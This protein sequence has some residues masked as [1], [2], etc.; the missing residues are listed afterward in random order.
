[1]ILLSRHSSHSGPPSRAAPSLTPTSPLTSALPTALW[2]AGTHSRRLGSQDAD[3]D[4]KSWGS[5]RLLGIN[6]CERKRRGSP[7]GQKERSAEVKASPGRVMEPMLPLRVVLSRPKWSAFLS[8][9]GQSGGPGKGVTAGRQ[10]SA[11]EATREAAD[12]RQLS[13]PGQQAIPWGL[14]RPAVPLAATPNRQ[15]VGEMWTSCLRGEPRVVAADSQTRPQHSLQLYRGACTREGTDSAASLNCIWPR[16]YH[17]CQNP[18]GSRHR[19]LTLAIASV[20]CLDRRCPIRMASVSAL[21]TGSDLF[22]SMPSP[23]GVPLITTQSEVLSK[24]E[25]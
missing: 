12:S 20:K 15:G 17:T 23:A 16:V 2:R 11:A 8:G 7:I 9:V 5:Q 18:E 10:L 21:M 6:A 25:R 19:D 1:M 3:A 13:A 24:R 4:V 22:D 14:R